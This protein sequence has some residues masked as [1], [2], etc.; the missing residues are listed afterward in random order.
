MVHRLEVAVVEQSLNGSR[1]TLM[2]PLDAVSASPGIVVGDPP[3]T[4]PATEFTGVNVL[5]FLDE[6]TFPVDKVPDFSI[7]LGVCMAVALS[8]YRV[9]ED[10]SVSP[11]VRFQVTPV[12]TYASFLETLEVCFGLLN[13]PECDRPALNVFMLGL[14]DVSTWTR[15]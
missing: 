2:E 8:A 5:L 4:T 1:C 10:L 14:D 3:V 9:A 15:R 12:L 6:L 13:C 11:I 7:S